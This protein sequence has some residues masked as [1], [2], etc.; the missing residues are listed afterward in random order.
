MKRLK[1]KKG[2][3]YP[4]AAGLKIVREAGGMSKLTDE[5]RKRVNLKH[6]KV[7]EFCDDLPEES[8]EWLIESGKVE[9]I[10]ATPAAAIFGR[11]GKGGD[12]E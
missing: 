12:D 11:R 5:Q 7:G 8:R 6:V 3:T 1:A 2:L 10:E 4:D 9:E